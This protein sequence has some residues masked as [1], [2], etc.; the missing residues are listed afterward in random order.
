M[1]AA[2]LEKFVAD[3]VANIARNAPLTIKALKT[4]LIEIAKDP[5]MRNLADCEQVV[6]DCFASQDFTEGRTAFMEKRKA[7]FKGR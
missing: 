5:D 4:C 3:Y 6:D 7:S 1:P 2:D